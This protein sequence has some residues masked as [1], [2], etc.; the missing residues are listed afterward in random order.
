MGQMAAPSNPEPDESR[1]SRPPSFGAA[2]P[3]S[4]YGWK[5]HWYIPE[6]V[7]GVIVMVLGSLAVW[8]LGIGTADPP[9]G[10]VSDEAAASE[11]PF[12]TQENYAK[13]QVG[14]TAWELEDQLG[15]ADMRHPVRLDAGMRQLYNVIDTGDDDSSRQEGEGT[16]ASP[17]YEEMIWSSEQMI[18]QAQ[19]HMAALLKDGKVIARRQWGIE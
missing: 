13:I 17:V 1:S 6:I 19:Q 8:S 9:P 10:E 18:K 15:P 7:V 14:V 11:E 2:P 16:D 4:D 5:R 3:P 12:F